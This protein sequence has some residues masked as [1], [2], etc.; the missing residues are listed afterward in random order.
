M[1]ISKKSPRR[2]QDVNYYENIHFAMDNMFLVCS[3]YHHD[4]GSLK[5][6]I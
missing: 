3:I 6:S 5:F 1:Y 2:S 4:T